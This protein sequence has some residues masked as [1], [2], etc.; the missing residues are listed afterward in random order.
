MVVPALLLVFAW[1]LTSPVRALQ[2]DCFFCNKTGSGCDFTLDN[3]YD[4]VVDQRPCGKNETCIVSDIQGLGIA[5]GCQEDCLRFCSNHG[6]RCT[7]CME[8]LCNVGNWSLYK[9]SIVGVQMSPYPYQMRCNSTNKFYWNWQYCDGDAECKDGSDEINCTTPATA[10]TPT[11]PQ[12]GF[13]DEGCDFESSCS[14]ENRNVTGGLVW[15]NNSGSTASIETGPGAD[16]TRGDALGSYLHIETSG[17]DVNASALYRSSLYQFSTA[18]CLFRFAYHMIGTNIGTLEVRAVNS[19]GDVLYQ[20]QRVGQQSDRWILGGL[21]LP[22]IKSSFRIEIQATHTSGFQGDIAIDDLEFINCDPAFVVSKCGENQLPCKKTGLCVDA[23]RLCDFVDD[24]LDGTDEDPTVCAGPQECNTGVGGAPGYCT[25]DKNLCGWQVIE[26]PSG[27]HWQTDTAFTVSLDTGPEADHTNGKGVYLHLETSAPAQQGDIAGLRSRIFNPPYS[28]DCHFRF[29]YNMFGASTGILRV[30]LVNV[31]MNG[32]QKEKQLVFVRLG[33]QGFDW[34]RAEVNIHTDSYFML[35]IEGVRGSS[36]T[37]DIAIDD[38][39]FSLGC[40]EQAAFQPAEQ[41]VTSPSCDFETDSCYWSNS[42]RNVLFWRRNQGATESIETGPSVDHTF[43]NETGYYIYVEMSDQGSTLSVGEQGRFYSPLLNYTNDSAAMFFWYHMLGKGVGCFD[44]EVLCYD[45]PECDPVLTKR[46]WQT[47]GDQGVN[48]LPDFVRTDVCKSGNIF[49]I[50]LVATFS[51]EYIYWGEY[52]DIAVDD[53]WFGP[54]PPPPPC[55]NDFDCGN[56]TCVTKRLVCDFKPDCQN[57]ADEDFCSYD[58]DFDVGWCNWKRR[59]REDYD[60]MFERQSTA[61][62]VT[63][64]TGPASDRSGNGLYAVASV[65]HGAIIRGTHTDLYS[66]VFAETGFNCTVSFWYHMF[67]EDVGNLAVNVK[68]PQRLQHVWHILGDQGNMWHQA[69]VTIGRRF[70]FELIFEVTSGPDFTD[71][72][73]YQGDI[74]IDDVSFSNCLAEPNRRCRENEFICSNGHCINSDYV[75]DYEHD[76]HDG[77]DEINCPYVDGRCDFQETGC[78]WLTVESPT[79]WFLDREKTISTATGPSFDHTYQNNSGYYVYA[80]SSSP[81]PNGGSV[82]SLVYQNSFPAVIDG[83]CKFRFWYHMYGYHMGK[84]EVVLSQVNP[85]TS[86]TISRTVIWS[87]EGDQGNRWHRD[88]V[89]VNSSVSYELSVVANLGPSFLSDMALDDISP[90]LGCQLGAPPPCSVG[91]SVCKSGQCLWSSWFCDGDN[92]CGDNSDETNCRVSRD[93]G[94]FQGKCRNGTSCIPFTVVCDGNKD[95]TDG[96]DEAFCTNGTCSSQRMFSCAKGGCLTWTKVC[97][98]V[99][100]CPGGSDENLA[101]CSQHSTYCNFETGL[102]DWSNVQGGDNFDWWSTKNALNNSGYFMV[103][104]QTHYNSGQKTVLRSRMF[105][106]PAASGCQVTYS[107]YL[108]AGTGSSLQV[109]AV[110]TGRSK[111]LVDTAVGGVSKWQT[112]KAVVTT[113]FQYQLEFVATL[114]DSEG[115][116]VGLDS[117]SQGPGCSRKVHVPDSSSRVLIDADCDFES[118]L[119][120]WENEWGQDLNWI[121]HRG[122]TNTAAKNP[123]YPTGPTH[124]HTLYSDTGFYL[125]IDSSLDDNGVASIT[126]PMLHYNTT[127]RRLT[128]WYYMYGENVSCL[129]VVFLCGANFE[130]VA[131]KLCGNQQSSWKQAQVVTPSLCL[132]YGVKIKA[133]TNGGKMGDIAIDDIKFDSETTAAPPCGTGFQCRDYWCIDEHFVCDFLRHCS[134]GSDERDCTTNCTFEKD[135]CNWRPVPVSGEYFWERATVF[136]HLVGLFGGPV[137]DHTTQQTSGY[138]AAADSY[139]SA[140]DVQAELR[141]KPFGRSGDEC[142]MKFYYHLYDT[143]ANSLVVFVRGSGTGGS[144]DSYKWSFHDNSNDTVWHL[145]TVP[146]GHHHDFE[147]VFQTRSGINFDGTVAVDDITFE[148]C[149][150]DGHENETCASGQLYCSTGECVDKTHVCDYGFDC[151]NHSDEYNCPI[152]SGRCAFDNSDSCGWRN[153]ARDSTYLWY[154]AQGSTPSIGTGPS[155][156]KTTGT[157]NGYYAYIETS[158]VEPGGVYRLVSPWYPP[159]S[160]NSCYF[161]FWYHMFG[162]HITT[163]SLYVESSSS[164]I[165]RQLI[166]SKKGK[167][168]NAWLRGE[169]VDITAAVRW[170]FVFESMSGESWRGDIAVDGLSPSLGCQTGTAPACEPGYSQCSRFGECLPRRWFCDGVVDCNDGSDENNCPDLRTSPCWAYMTECATQKLTSDPPCYWN[171]WWCDGTSDCT[172]KSDEQGCSVSTSISNSGKTYPLNFMCTFE[173]DECYWMESHSDDADW[174]RIRGPT[175]SNLTG[176]QVDHTLG[177]EAGYYLYMEGNRLLHNSVVRLRSPRYE[178]AGWNC[179]L[180]FAYHMYGSGVG[181]LEVLVTS[182]SN[183]VTTAPKQKWLQRGDQGNQWYVGRVALSDAALSGPYRVIFKATRGT[184]TKSDIALDDIAFANCDPDLPHPDCDRYDDY[185]CSDSSC[186]SREDLCDFV[187]DCAGG[188]DELPVECAKVYGRCDFESSMCDWTNIHGDDF[189]WLPKGGQTPSSNTGPVADHTTGASHGRY[190]FIEASDP[191][192]PGDTARLQ[193]AVYAAPHIK[194]NCTARFFYHMLGSQIGQLT[195]YVVENGQQE[196]AIW[197][198]KG[199]QSSTWQKAVVPFQTDFNFTFILEAV[200]NGSGGDI[201]FDDFSLGSLCGRPLTE[202][203]IEP[204]LTPNCD[205]EHDCSGW[206]HSIHDVGALWM[207][208]QGYTSSIVTGPRSDHTFMNSSGHYLYIEASSASLQIASFVSPL[209]TFSPLNRKIS[210][211]YF[212]FGRSIGCLQLSALC[213]QRG[214]SSVLWM[215]CENQGFIWRRAVVDLFLPACG[216]LELHFTGAL[217]RGFQGDIAID[218]IEF[219]TTFDVPTCPTAGQFA[220]NNRKCIK[221]SQMCDFNDDCGDNSDETVCSTNCTFENGMCNWYPAVDSNYEWRQQQGPIPGNV[222][223]PDVDHTFGTKLGFYMYTEHRTAFVFDE[224]VAYLESTVFSR[225]SQGCQ[226]VFWYHLHGIDFGTLVVQVKSTTGRFTLWHASNSTGRGWKQAVVNI[227]LQH[228]VKVEISASYD[229]TAVNNYVAIDDIMLSNCEAPVPTA[230]AKGQYTCSNDYCI[231]DDLFCD[232]N[233]DCGDS[234]DEIN[235]PATD[236][237]FESGTCGWFVDSALDS[238]WYLSSGLTPSVFT[239]PR[240]DHTYGNSTGH[241]LHIEASGGTAGD[242]A[243]ISLRNIFGHVETNG[244]CSIRFWYH[245]YGDSKAALQVYLK[246]ADTDKRS[247]LLE[248]TGVNSPVWKRASVPIYSN[249]PFYVELEGIRGSTYRS[250]VAIDDISFTAGCFGPPVPRQCQ[251]WQFRCDNLHC[252]SKR[253]VCDG[254]DDCGDHS[255]EDSFGSGINCA[256]PSSFPSFGHTGDCDFESGYCTWKNDFPT[257]LVWILQSGSTPSSFTGPQVDHTIGTSMGHYIYIETSSA[258]EGSYA[259]LI[260]QVQSAADQFLGCRLDFYYHMYGGDIGSLAVAIQR[261]DNSPLEILWT[262]SGNQGLTWIKGSV[263]LTV[264]QSYRVVFQATAGSSFAGDIALDDVQFNDCGPGPIAEEPPT[265][266]PGVGFG[267]CY[268]NSC[269]CCW[270]NSY[271]SDNFDWSFGTIANSVINA[272]TDGSNSAKGGFMYLKDQHEQDVSDFAH[273]ES[274]LMRVPKKSG[275]CTLSFKLYSNKVSAP[276][277][278]FNTRI[279]V[280]KRRV[281]TFGGSFRVT[282]IVNRQRNWMSVEPID[283]YSSNTAGS[284]FRVVI[285]A[286]RQAGNT[287][288]QTAIDDL[289]FSDGCTQYFVH[290]GTCFNNYD[291]CSRSPFPDFPA[292]NTTVGNCAFEGDSCG[293]QLSQGTGGSTWNTMS[294]RDITGYPDNTVPSQDAS[295]SEDGQVIFIPAQG[296]SFWALMESPH[297]VSAAAS[298]RKRSPNRCEITFSYILYSNGTTLLLELY[299]RGGGTV[300]KIWNASSSSSIPVNWKQ[301]T[302]AATLQSNFRVDFVAR[303]EGTASGKTGYFAVDQVSFSGCHF[304]ETPVDSSS[305]NYRALT[306]GCADGGREGFIQSTLIAGCSGKWFGYASL[307]QAST[308][309]PCGGDFPSDSLRQMCRSP[310]DL[311]DTKNGWR[312]CGSLGSVRDITDRTSASACYTAGYGRFSAAIDNCNT[313]NACQKPNFGMKYGCS[314][315]KASCDAPFCCGVGCTGT[316]ACNGGVFPGQTFSVPNLMSHEGCSHITSAQADGVLCCYDPMPT[317]PPSMFC[318]TCTFETNMCDW[319]FVNG[320]ASWKRAKGAIAP[321][322]TP[323]FDH[324]IGSQ[325]GSYIYLSAGRSTGQAIMESGWIYPSAENCSHCSL[326]LYYNIFSQASLPSSLEV[327]FSSPLLEKQLWSVTASSAHSQK[328]QV[329]IIELNVSSTV[330][331]FKIVISGIQGDQGNDISL[332]DISFLPCKVPTATA[333]TATA[334]TATLS[335]TTP[336]TTTPSTTTPSTT[337]PSTTTPSTT[338]LSTT[339]ISTTKASTATPTKSTT[340]TKTPTVFTTIMSSQYVTSKSTPASPDCTGYCKNEGTCVVRSNTRTCSCLIHYSGDRCETALDLPV[341]TGRPHEG[342]SDSNAGRDAGIAVAVIALVIIVIVVVVVLVILW[343]R[344]H[345]SYAVNKQ[346]PGGDVGISNPVYGY[347]ESQAGNQNQYDVADFTADSLCFQCLHS[348]YFVILS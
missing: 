180:T 345:Q 219:N 295:G 24:C 82:F 169:V 11:Y 248:I 129:E 4:N 153:N 168:G 325:K 291:V 100:D 195:L 25:L 125:Y 335:T 121:R 135:M 1:T 132:H 174:Q 8:N 218:D 183:G 2:I 204:V 311:C 51:Y 45:D 30:Y 226:L 9:P 307:A 115:G 34:E 303:Q 268:F 92:D 133:T 140:F 253:W 258:F 328:W 109:Y 275:E 281:D 256:L 203:S 286:Q 179:S 131:W 146:I 228:Q 342:K 257:E 273:L 162:D 263:S 297:V 278:I 13:P 187:E 67:G 239:G 332:D 117:I 31:D 250:D 344:K 255:D 68:T 293:W 245:M 348:L 66:T 285:A 225:L 217:A 36:F 149:A 302:A 215:K 163:L 287:E 89:S 76:C 97:D 189:N 128:F 103:A 35:E 227:G 64:L 270:G 188:G 6:S 134:D 206:Q 95:C 71:T 186:I 96:A 61:R 337:T 62:L 334:S 266:E 137:G 81:R 216:Q 341:V 177:T 158:G 327:H 46:V 141:S 199:S 176:P 99:E 27:F 279:T 317:S 172:D 267:D 316:S 119:C 210:F 238:Q 88:F 192:Q 222:N 29:Y 107:Y 48:W 242:R 41:V 164:L 42:E 144:L 249:V 230:C 173:K 90:T 322:G 326:Q 318:K 84:L 233:N 314:Q 165:P 72:V 114:G 69:N 306:T 59:R 201:A 333:S 154:I 214:D 213:K 262:K 38:F 19:T 15:T 101:S 202:V 147:I 301:A 23:L 211:W 221:Q 312:L 167:Q 231:S 75:C 182:A 159:T 343:R 229:A 280:N 5:R 37:G 196:R 331:R 138:F 261:H 161:T 309:V 232:F 102:C 254:V 91:Q 220:C 151:G 40:A 93:C 124:D 292:G 98:F 296:D 150:D 39:S 207:R 243:V 120:I 198:K 118:S 205:F 289:K 298:S 283:L 308:G 197:S 321:P 18:S 193:S 240:R 143:A 16:H 246:N 53:I 166:W 294:M 324:T 32:K 264:E 175:R 74:A 126:S 260:S 290:S 277:R 65:Q 85:F 320:G 108:R 190:L 313:V 83:S 185:Q 112:R 284:H 87:K 157:E 52:S 156:D 3:Y 300:R 127:I 236:C 330:Q 178:A 26:T 252:I 77:S 271:Y 209:M 340:K 58:C 148:N 54:I 122:L 223:G 106:V 79:V 339:T 86:E 44:I 272:T 28:Y 17:V 116:D 329:A 14:W 251:Q 139:L 47:C 237:S 269:H 194:G 155:T 338:T 200:V 181:T 110:S 171:D 234:S 282:E 73:G 12:T 136:D 274:K 10:V 184:N 7:C 315:Y 123:Q 80:E 346:Q 111:I 21:P 323:R 33:P 142:V 70:E 276:R 94:I 43:D 212:M 152:V 305:Y 259:R 247:R 265:L 60:F 104:D 113:S 170:R 347:T 319:S 208:H 63:N 310:A 49:R 20:W 57:G 145:A 235:C 50:A 244:K 56:G 224:Q 105:D 160:D 191:R 336:S 241:Y 22:S 288:V 130:H 304:S 299:E 55:G 78:G